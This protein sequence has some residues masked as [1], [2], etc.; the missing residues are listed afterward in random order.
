M[1]T[2]NAIE[3]QKCKEVIWSTHQHDFRYCSCG[4]IAVDGGQEYTKVVGDRK[5]WEFRAIN[6][7]NKVFK[8]GTFK[9]TNDKGEILE[10]F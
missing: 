3:C 7:N 4:K 10:E 1:V 8:R 2:V 5:N 9:N 6:V